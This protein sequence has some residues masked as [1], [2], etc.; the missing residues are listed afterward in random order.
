MRAVYKL[1][2]SSASL[3]RLTTNII[4][5]L[6]LNLKDDSLVFLAGIVCRSHGI[7]EDKVMCVAALRHATSFLA[8]QPN[9]DFQTILPSLIVAILGT[10]VDIRGAAL[11]C[12]AV[13]AS[14]HKDLRAIYGFD[15]IYGEKSSVWRVF[16]SLL[17]LTHLRLLL[18]R[19]LA[20]SECCGC[21]KLCQP[22]HRIEGP[23]RP[24]WKLFQD[25][26]SAASHS[27]KSGLEG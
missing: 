1:A 2:N 27:D 20:I 17:H 4:R 23:H 22:Y 7:V 9:V 24:R 18:L 11:D 26:S 13:L 8:A 21:V 16:S 10:D 6:F 12:V 19:Q 3:P 15:T 14:N 25:I 5:A